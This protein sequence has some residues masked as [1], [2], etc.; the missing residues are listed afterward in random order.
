MASQ[1]SQKL[2]KQTVEKVSHLARLKLNEQE[3]A[4]AA[5]QLSA[6]LENF[7]LISQVDTKNVKPLLTPTDM[8]PAYRE[9]RA[10]TFDSEKAL[11]NAPEKSGRLFKVP[12]VV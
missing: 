4:E 12:P 10:E 5:E 11:A 3:I 9:D 8:E 2:T 1:P 7:E 6:I